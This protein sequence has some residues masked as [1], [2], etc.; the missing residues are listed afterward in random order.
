[1]Q[2]QAPASNG[3]A[4]ERNHL[5]VDKAN[6]AMVHFLS[7]TFNKNASSNPAVPDFGLSTQPS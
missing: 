7:K 5:V 3:E 2:V 4:P 6:R 1:M